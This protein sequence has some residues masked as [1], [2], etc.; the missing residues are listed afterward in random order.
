MIKKPWAGDFFNRIKGNQ[1]LQFSILFSIWWVALIYL[2]YPVVTN[3]PIFNLDDNALIDPIRE[4]HSLHQ[5]YKDILSG[6]IP[7]LQPIRDLTTWIDIQINHYLPLSTF[8][9]TNFILWLGI[10]YALY[11]ILIAL[12]FSQMTSFISMALYSVSPVMTT[13]V[14]WISSRKHLLSTF[15]ILWATL[16]IVEIARTRRWTSKGPIAIPILYLFSVLS[17]PI[18][19]LWPIF[20]FAYLSTQQISVLGTRRSRTIFGILLIIGALAAY[21]NKQYYLGPYLIHS[22]GVPKVAEEQA[23]GLKFLLIGRSFFQILFPLYPVLSIMYPGTPQGLVGLVLFSSLCIFI[24]RSYLK[25]LSIWALYFLLP[26]SVVTFKITNVYGSDSYLFNAGVGIWV[27]LT[28]ITSEVTSK[29]KKVLIMIPP[30]FAFLLAS[31]FSFSRAWTSPLSIWEKLYESDPSPMTTFSYGVYLLNSGHINH[32]LKHFLHLTYWYPD[33][34][35]LPKDVSMAIYMSAT[36]SP[37]KKLKLFKETPIKKGWPA[38]YAAWI[39]ADSSQYA[40]AH[41]ELQRQLVNLSE[42]T[43]DFRNNLETVL[44]DQFHFCRQKT[45]VTPPQSGDPKHDR[46]ELCHAEVQKYSNQIK[47]LQNLRKQPWRPEVFDRRLRE[48]GKISS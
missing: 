21:L 48:I 42:T 17:Q 7:D 2:F 12:S 15:F 9:F 43:P 28:K 11:R 39:Y 18:N 23:L 32:A 5:Y 44:A 27:L 1:N 13:S 46:L 47:T 33:I 4:V 29:S 14:S 22:Q 40:T 3:D 41:Q 10:L 8:H 16:Q 26:I 24:A 20:A 45:L 38:Y 36:L 34:D 19:I 6:R 31:S 35:A 30:F 25:P 37:E